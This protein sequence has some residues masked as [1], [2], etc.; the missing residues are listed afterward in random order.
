MATG[1]TPP[2]PTGLPRP[3]HVFR[4]DLHLAA[5]AGVRPRRA[6]QDGPVP[7]RG[8][9]SGMLD[10]DSA[11]FSPRDAGRNGGDAESRARHRD[12]RSAPWAGCHGWEPGAG[13]GRGDA[14]AAPTGARSDTVL[15]Q[16]VGYSAA[17]W[18]WAGPRFVGGHCGR[19][20]IRGDTAGEPDAGYGR[21]SPLAAGLP[22]PH[23]PWSLGDAPGRTVYPHEPGPLG[24]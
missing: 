5:V 9:R 1:F 2:T 7:G 18:A 13:Y 20:Q 12:S 16:S 21:R 8:G 17:G 23:H 3:W 19:V 24:V 4:H 6:G 10:G 15:V 14:C 22:R 11:P